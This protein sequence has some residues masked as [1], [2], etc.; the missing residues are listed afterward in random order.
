MVASFKHAADRNCLKQL[1][2]DGSGR[3][4]GWAARELDTAQSEK[5]G[6]KLPA[7]PPRYG[8]I[9]STCGTCGVTSGPDGA[10]TMLTSLRTPNSPGR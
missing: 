1:D 7:E 5:P 10:Q 4:G 2:I 9:S 8:T 3:L 6:A